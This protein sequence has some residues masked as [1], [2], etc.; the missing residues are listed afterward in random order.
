MVEGDIQGRLL[1]FFPGVYE[2]NNYR[3]LDARD[4]WNYLAV[5]ITSQRGGGPTDDRNREVLREGPPHQH[6][7]QPGRG[8]GHERSSPTAEVETL[9]YEIEQLRLRRP[10]CRGAEPHPRARISA[11]STSR[12]SRASGSA[13]SSV[14]ARAT[15]SRCS[16]TSGSTSS[17]RMGPGHGACRGA[18]DRD[19]GPVQGAVHG[20]KRAGG[21]HAGGGDLGSG[22][23]RAS[24][25]NCSASS[26]S[27]SACP[28]TISR[29]SFVMWL[30]HE[31]LEETSS[32]E[33]I[34][35]GRSR[36]RHGARQPLRLRPQWPGR[37]STPARTSPRTPADVK[38][39]LQKQFPEKPDVSIDEMIAKI[40]Q[41]IGDQRE[42]ALHADRPRRGP[43]VHRRQ[44]GAD[45][46]PCRTSRSNAAP[47]SGRTSCSSRTGQNALSGTPLLQRLQGRFPVTV[48]L[49]DTDVEQVTREVV[50]K[51]KPSA[52]TR[53]EALLD[54]A[55]RRDR[56]ATPGHQD[57]L[58]HPGPQ[59]ARP[60][61]PDP[62]RPA[63]VL[64]AG[65][66]GRGQGRHRRPAPQPTL[67]RL[68]RR[69]ADRRPAAGP[70]RQR[71]V[72]LRLHDQE[73]GAP[74][75]GV[76]LQEIAEN[77]RAA[78][79]RGGRRT[80]VPTLRPDLPDR[81]A[82]ARR[83]ARHRHP[84]QRRDARR[85]PRHRPDPQQRR[86]PQEGAGTARQAG[87]LRRRHAGRG[88]VPDAD[89]RGGRVEPGV[90]TWPG[91]GC[92]PTPA[93]ACAQRAVATPEVALQRGPQEGQAD[94]RRQQ[95]PRKIELHFGS[96]PPTATGA[97]IPV[98]V[99]DGWEF[100][101][102]TVLNDARTAGDTEAVVYGFIP[103][104]GPRN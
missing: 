41:A 58:H 28:A 40:T 30:R 45:P 37:S 89:P 84:G 47:G 52:R 85:P 39:L 42:A 102:K 43:A 57:R 86:A 51:K 32:R 81:P 67:G 46:R 98:W 96:T 53:S 10:V 14:R 3:L 104:P 18:A 64:G 99:R 4:G 33:H 93:R 100:E 49:Q 92:W 21:L 16:S 50:L 38:L 59:A 23:G 71:G 19:Q 26:S 94:P 20:A 25:W 72:H 76:L 24:A 87:D 103:A 68:R 7:A 35:T 69:A 88:R 60:G 79:E 74:S 48:E 66:P 9:R 83:A 34:W 80:P 29:A 13:A 27:R 70:R 75:P 77:D 61:L 36:L 56:A 54:D 65:A 95:E 6:A 63:P 44:R 55:Q 2:Q 90:S 73:Q 11:T 17:S 78:E 8:Q 12:S 101:E 97:A 91:T 62:P 31:G 5:P 22:A 82:A 15:W 1:V